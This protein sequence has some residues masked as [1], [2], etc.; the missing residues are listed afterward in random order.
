MRQAHLEWVF[1][2]LNEPKRLFHRY[3]TGNLVFLS[4]I[5]RIRNT[6]APALDLPLEAELQDIAV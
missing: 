2:L 1:R 4:R 6:Y 3:I 5:N